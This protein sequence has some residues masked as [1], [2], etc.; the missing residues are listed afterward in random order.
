MKKAALIPL[1]LLCAAP[2]HASDVGFDVNV[3]VGNR[4]SAPPPVVISQPPV[5][6]S[7]PPPV[8]VIEE[9]PEFIIPPSL[10]FYVAV[11]VPY[12]LFYVSG[13]YYLYRDNGWYRASYYDGPWM[14]VKYKHL[15]PGLRRHKFDRI[16]A[17]RDQE[18]RIYEV[19]RDR[20][21]GRHFR[22][23]WR[24]HRRHDHDH[25]KDRRRGD[26]DDHWKDRRR[27]DH[28]NWKEIKQAEKQERKRH[29]HGRDD[30]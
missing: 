25:S 6:V 4:P 28:Q 21:R 5:V 27:G 16:R 17:Y 14:R 12:D 11:G 8:V 20:Y 13:A 3:S 24:E 2:L 22:P 7:A 18:V 29:K 10:G 30:D 26:H 15:P 1:L 19:D 23:E 9:P